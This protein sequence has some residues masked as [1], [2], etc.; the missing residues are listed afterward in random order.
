MELNE[1]GDVQVLILDLRVYVF[2]LY[3]FYV[4]YNHDDFA[5]GACCVSFSPTRY[6]H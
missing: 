5:T 1:T 2:V 3:A 6:H 4:F